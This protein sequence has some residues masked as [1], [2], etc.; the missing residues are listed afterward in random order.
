[1]SEYLDYEALDDT[2][3]SDDSVFESNDSDFEFIDNSNISDG[4]SVNFYQRIDNEFRRRSDLRERSGTS[5]V[6]RNG[7]RDG[8]NAGETTASVRGRSIERYVGSSGSLYAQQSETIDGNQEQKVDGKETQIGGV[9]VRGGGGRR[10][11][12]NRSAS[13]ESKK[14]ATTTKNDNSRE[15]QR[16]RRYDNQ[17]TDSDSSS[18]SDIETEIRQ[19]SSMGTDSEIHSNASDLNDLVNKISFDFTSNNSKNPTLL[20]NSEQQQQQRREEIEIGIENSSRRSVR[21][22]S[23]T[24]STRFLGQFRTRIRTWILEKFPRRR[25]VHD[26]V[27]NTNGEDGLEGFR[28]ASK[29]RFGGAIWVVAKHSDHWHVIHDCNYNGSW[30]R[31][32][33]LQVDNTRRVSR[34]VHQFGTINWR[35]L[36]NLIIY[37]NKNGRELHYVQLG[38]TI[39]YTCGQIGDL[40]CG[41]STQ[42][43]KGPM[44]AGSH[45][46]ELYD[47]EQ[48]DEYAN[49]SKSGTFGNGNTAGHQGKEK[50]KS[51]SKGD[52]LLEYLEKFTVTPLS[53]IFTTFEWR[54]SKYKYL[55]K[56]NPLLNTCM[57]LHMINISNWTLEELYSFAN[58]STILQYNAPN[59]CLND[60][61]YNLEDSVFVL[62]ELLKFQFNGIVHFE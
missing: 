22:A 47:T 30:C 27:V 16:R 46:Q 41:E 53:N 15:R 37:L 48:C 44:V 1:M 62:D 28:K 12:R 5:G 11:K 20:Q 2:N 42:T 25:F 3:N 24:N 54:Q 34:R 49:L 59:G 56:N 26:I 57:S 52:L 17:F 32:A 4:E 33:R 10:E 19:L 23:S 6:S 35:H 55:P 39:R 31:C 13:E 43:L 38:R 21:S 14:S 61:Y 51:K 7:A 50:R 60:Y 58:K 9:V 36:Y 40:S 18:A 29:I 45:L 8:G